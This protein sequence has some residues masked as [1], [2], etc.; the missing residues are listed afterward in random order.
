MD[1]NNV[2][3]VGETKPQERSTSLARKSLKLIYVYAIATGAIFTFM[4]YWDTVF[5]A[6]TGPA[7]FLAFVLMTLAILPIAF[8]YCELAPL[9]PSVGAELVYNTVGIN[10]HVGFFSS[11]LIMAAWIAVPP[12]AVMAILEWLNRVI[13][14]QLEFNVIMIA[15]IVMLVG[16]C[17]LSL[18]DIQIAGKLQLFMLIGAIFGCIAS[19]VAIFFSGHWSLSNFTPFFR[20]TL[21]DGGF[22]GWVIGL[23]L[24]ITP[25]FG[26]ETVPQMV[27]EGDFPIKDSTKAIWG[28]VVTCGIVYSLFFLAI[29]GLGSFEELLLLNDAGEVT[30]S[31]LSITAMENILGWKLWALIFGVFAVL[32]AIGTCLLGFWLSTVRL[33][34]AMG[35]QNFLPKAFAYVNKKQQPVLPNVFLLVISI[36]FIAIMNSSTFMND[37]FNLMAFGCAVAYAI[38][39]ISAIRI[40]YKYP[41]WNRPYVLKGGMATRIIALLLAVFI[42]VLCTL[43]QGVG[44]WKSF[45]VYV[46]I[47]IVLWLWMVFVKWPKTPVVM[48]TP[49]GEK[50]Y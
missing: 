36:I 37:F 45:F 11:W 7:T 15:G 33:M 6:Y 39:M 43:G 8:V 16:Y 26:F 30:V 25:Y 27:E 31:F 41:H 10:K 32:F 24:V 3:N 40:Y 20:S 28:S 50:E 14:L 34:Y 4:G 35:R 18:G 9:F 21:G 23:G 47:G 48:T 2:P 38:T 12:A 29:G 13:G 49:D 22:G 17:L 42:A 44:S 1:S 19:A 5:I 46:A